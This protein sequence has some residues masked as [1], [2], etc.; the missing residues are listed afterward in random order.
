MNN[1]THAEIFGTTTNPCPN[2]CTLPAGHG[3]DSEDNQTMYRGHEHEIGH[4]TGPSIGTGNRVSA[5]VAVE[6]LEALRITDT[7]MHVEETDPPHIV[8]DTKDYGLSGP[9]AREV[10]R[11]LV[12]AAD[13][14]DE[15]M[16]ERS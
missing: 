3:Y 12:E 1:A 10:A 13:R 6:S 8:L 9:Q 14:W 7:G 15:F 4:L 16:N 2:W 5:Y 11:M